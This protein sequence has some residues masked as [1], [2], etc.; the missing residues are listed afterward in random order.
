[1]LIV[2]LSNVIASQSYAAETTGT[3]PEIGTPYI[4]P[5]RELNAADSAVLSHQGKRFFVLKNN[6]LTE[7]QIKPFKRLKVYDF[8]INRNKLTIDDKNAFKMFALPNGKSLVIALTKKLYLF[9]LKQ[10]K[11]VSEAMVKKQT[12]ITSVLKGNKLI[13]F[14]K[15]F[16]RDLDE[17]LPEGQVNYYKSKVP[18][19]VQVWNAQTLKKESDQQ[20]LAPEGADITNADRI[21]LVGNM[22]IKISPYGF[23]G[24]N[25]GSVTLLNSQTYQPTCMIYGQAV[26]NTFISFKESNLYIQCAS[27]LKNYDQ[28]DPYILEGQPHSKCMPLELNLKSR[29]ARFFSSKPNLNWYE[30]SKYNLPYVALAQLQISNIDNYVL[31]RFILL[32]LKA[33]SQWRLFQFSDGE[34]VLINPESGEFKATPGARKHLTMKYAMREIVPMNEAT[35]RKFNLSRN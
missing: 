20:F 17:N 29:R 21:N 2:L 6:M 3:Q 31:S 14:T 5:N 12:V 32:D 24:K 25:F 28:Q 30:H 16:S 27:G 15:T 7:Y 19:R 22:L 9:D 13:L 23:G 1:M 8:P 10:E 26:S 35:F 34:T 11:I 4:K 33:N 18:G